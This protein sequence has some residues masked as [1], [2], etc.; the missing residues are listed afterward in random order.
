MACALAASD[1]KT[2]PAIVIE[3]IRAR[4]NEV[5]I[6]FL[7]LSGQLYDVD[8]FMG[9]DGRVVIREALPFAVYLK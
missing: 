7:P 2:E 1:R 3:Q 9:Q 8:S 4:A 5:F 6:N